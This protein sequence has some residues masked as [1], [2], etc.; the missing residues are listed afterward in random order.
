L[1][2]VLLHL[3]VPRASGSSLHAWFRQGLGEGGVAKAGTPAAVQKVVA[4]RQEP[5]R[6]GVVT[7]H[8]AH[9]VHTG[10]GG[11]P[12][13][14]ALLLRDPVQRV[15][16]LFRYIRGLP[17]HDLHET[18]NR[19]GMTIARFYADRLPGSGPRN[20]MVAQL[21]GVLGGGVTLDEEHLELACRHLFGDD[22][23][24][25]LAEDPA[26][27]LA[28]AA[29]F[30]RFEK[31]PALPEL[32]RPG[33]RAAWGGTPEDLEAIAAANRLDRMLYER[34]KARLAAVG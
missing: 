11:H 32:N 8:F 25:G 7:G 21:S 14:Y 3:H 24:F 22:V 28:R 5:R 9:G 18:L 20:G 15:L 26:P 19:P 1:L 10:L 31:T 33:A 17:A 4:A 27:F 2:P 6:P 29:E 12:Y 30:L 34:A 16:S 13:R 23:M